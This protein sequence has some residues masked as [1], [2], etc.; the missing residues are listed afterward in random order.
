MI[1]NYFILLRNVIELKK[2]LKNSYLNEI[3][4]QEKD[5]LFLRIST[6][7]LPFRHL[8]ISTDQNMPYIVLKNDHRKA[9]KNTINFWDD[10]LPQKIKFISIALNERIIKIELVNVILFL[11]IRGN[12]TNFFLMDKSNV[13]HAFKKFKRKM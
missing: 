10:H 13:L 1:K 5:K 11:V 2:Q 3:Y 9:K 6:Q 4:T 12:G 8:V 7:E